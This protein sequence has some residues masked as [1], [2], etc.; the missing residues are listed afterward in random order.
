M[1][2]KNGRDRINPES[3]ATNFKEKELNAES[4]RNGVREPLEE[5]RKKI[6]ERIILAESISPM[7]MDPL[8]KEKIL[9]SLWAQRREIEAKIRLTE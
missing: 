3:R 6:I 5:E 8:E 1:M 2:P 9:N 7:R 4:F